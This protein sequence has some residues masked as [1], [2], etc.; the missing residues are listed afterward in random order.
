MDNITDLDKYRELKQKK[1]EEE[2][3][4]KQEDADT[5]LFIDLVTKPL[6]SLS[7]EQQ[8]IYDEIGMLLQFQLAEKF[9]M[10]LA[11]FRNQI[12]VL[13][14]IGDMTFEY[15]GKFQDIVGRGLGL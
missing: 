8:L 11:I 5:E 7:V 15:L 13:N 12:Y 2:K 1:L 14:Y 6:A 9:S 3:Q 4:Q 10:A